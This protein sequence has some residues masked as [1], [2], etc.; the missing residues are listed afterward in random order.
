MRPIDFCKPHDFQAPCELFDS[1][2]REEDSVDAASLASVIA[3]F[4]RDL[5]CSLEQNGSR[6]LRRSRPVSRSATRFGEDCEAPYGY[7]ASSSLRRSRHSRWSFFGFMRVRRRCLWHPRH[8]SVRRRTSTSRTAR[9]RRSVKSVGR[10]RPQVPSLVVECAPFL[11]RFRDRVPRRPP[12]RIEPPLRGG[13]G[14]SLSIRRSC[15]STFARAPTRPFEFL[16]R[17]RIGARTSRRASCNRV[18]NP[19]ARPTV[20]RQPALRRPTSF[21]RLSCRPRSSGAGSLALPGR[22]AIRDARATL[23]TTPRFPDALLDKH[24]ASR[25]SDDERIE[26]SLHRPPF[27]DAAPR[28]LE[29]V[30]RGGGRLNLP[31]GRNRFFKAIPPL[32]PSIVRSAAKPHERLR[33]RVLTSK[34]TYR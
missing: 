3:L 11:G 20:R 27:S 15:L 22:F 13:A 32:E 12:L 17:A 21:R 19:R 2:L 10:C 31:A 1:P 9:F 33:S 4:H 25:A 6:A 26:V 30:P 8:M 29:F 14:A 5:P 7:F 34:R 28:T 16:Q 24:P 23:T 18:F